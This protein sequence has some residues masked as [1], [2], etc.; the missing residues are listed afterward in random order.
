MYSNSFLGLTRRP[1]RG[2]AGPRRVSI[3]TGPRPRVVRV[4]VEVDHVV[5][6]ILRDGRHLTFLGDV[7]VF[8]N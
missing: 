5:D 1:M 8:A 2:A 3:T 7:I 4:P 6:K